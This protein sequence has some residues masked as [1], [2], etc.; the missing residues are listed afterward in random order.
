MKPKQSVILELNNRDLIS[1]N[2]IR[3]SALIRD[4]ESRN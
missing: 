4:Y 3:S 1:I 2:K